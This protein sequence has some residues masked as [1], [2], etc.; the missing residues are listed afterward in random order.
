MTPV[1]RTSLAATAGDRRRE[2]RPGQRAGLRGGPRSAAVRAA[3]ATAGLAPQSGVEFGERVILAHGSEV[4]GP[5]RI[6]VDVNSSPAARSCSADGT[7]GARS[8]WFP[9]GDAPADGRP[10]GTEAPGHDA[11]H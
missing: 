7:Y 2:Q 3:M 6:G 4:R 5:A 11:G 8:P 1:R 9:V 10:I